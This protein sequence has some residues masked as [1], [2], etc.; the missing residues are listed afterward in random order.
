MYIG[1]EAMY[2]T[3][4]GASQPAGTALPGAIGSIG[5]ATG[6]QSSTSAWNFTLR[7]HKDFL[8]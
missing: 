4:T 1:V 6:F 3:M 7:M 8:P 2:E 5:S